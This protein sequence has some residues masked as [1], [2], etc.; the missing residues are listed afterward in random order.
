MLNIICNYNKANNLN[1]IRRVP[2]VSDHRF[3][4]HSLGSIDGSAQALYEMYHIN[5]EN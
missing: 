3:F 2:F 4:Y 5:D 1:N